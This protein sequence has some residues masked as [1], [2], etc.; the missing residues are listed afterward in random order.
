MESPFLHFPNLETA[1]EKAVAAQPS[2]N[3]HYS[4]SPFLT[5]SKLN[6]K[7]QH[8][9][10]RAEEFVAVMDELYDE[11]FNEYTEDLLNE[12]QDI[13][14]R[15]T[16]SE[17]YMSQEHYTNQ[18]VQQYYQPFFHEVNTLFDNLVQLGHEVDDNRKS[19]PDIE[20]FLSNY[21]T[22]GRDL[23]DVQE[24]WLG[25][26]GK[27]VKKGVKKL[28]SVAKKG[29]SLVAKYGFGWILNKL[30]KIVLPFLKSFLQKGI[31]LLPAQYRNMAT[32]LAAKFLPQASVAQSPTPAT[33]AT[34]QD[35]AIPDVPADSTTDVAENVQDGMNAATAQLLTTTNEIEWELTEAELNSIG[36]GVEEDTSSMLSAARQQFITQ[37]E[38]MEEGENPEPVVEQFLPAITT[39]LKLAMP[40]VG[41]RN[42]IINW[43][44]PLMAKLIA[45]VTGKANATALSRLMIDKGMRMLN[46]ET[47]EE[48]SATG[49]KAV[50]ETVENTIRQIPEFPPYVLQDR[51][52]FER[53]VVNAFERSAAAY[54]PDILPE[55]IYN[56][57]PDLRE[58]NERAVVW[59]NDQE[60][61][62]EDPTGPKILNEVI[63]TELN[64][65]IAQQIKTFGG[66]P[67]SVFLRDRLGV[68]VNRTLPVRVHLFESSAGNDLCQI[69]KKAKRTR[70]LGS[71]ARS[72]WMQLH[73]LTSVAAGLLMKEP[74][75]GCKKSQ[76]KCLSKRK[77][78]KGH[79]FYYL[80]IDGARPQF[81]QMLNGKQ[82]LRRNTCLKA[83]LNF[84]ANEIRMNLYL[85][86]SD[87]QAIAVSLRKKQPETAHVL[88]MMALRDGIKNV[89]SYGK[90][91]SLKI[92]HTQVIPGS[93]SGMAIDRVPPVV[94]EAFTKALSNWAGKKLIDFLREQA[95]QFVQAAEDHADGVTLQVTLLSP[96]DLTVIRNILSGDLSEVKE[97]L[98]SGQPA[99]LLIQANAGYDFR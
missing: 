75:L 51:Q 15:H 1:P 60:T 58:S 90:Y 66:I 59:K 68:Q 40:L 3:G 33:G 56:E 76:E 35:P 45:P 86:E 24:Q 25:K 8:Y 82:V 67:L 16:T 21:E 42:S 41:G 73:P 71:G 61:S 93:R 94:T 18:L 79:R 2:R 63:E 78:S 4:E 74:G 53:Y 81:F 64:P 72:A 77:A 69:A 83:R 32:S 80:E 10:K 37:L 23:S 52:L 11:E 88:L 57:Q 44:A 99:E 92:I 12:M 48:D 26:L 62:E 20:N 5:A 70:G 22:S 6:G 54:L 43:T 38:N 95:T 96:P 27:W 55:K 47:P 17:G 28:A 46:L 49:T 30:K 31:N 85:S 29:V 65:F 89:F 36:E 34:L 50:A 19:V 91:D 84:P 7:Q 39:A 98:F 9:D 87:A 97:S 13:R 14:T